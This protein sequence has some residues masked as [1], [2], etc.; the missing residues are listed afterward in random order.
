ML[1]EIT[2]ADAFTRITFPSY[3]PGLRAKV[4]SD[5][6]V[7]KRPDH[8]IEAPM[9]SIRVTV[10][11]IVARM[12][13]RMVLLGI[14]TLR[15]EKVPPNAWLQRRGAARFNSSY[16]A[17]DKMKRMLPPRPLQAIVRLRCGIICIYTL[18]QLLWL[19]RAT[20]SHITS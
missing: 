13:F 20:R 14:R 6:F 16:V 4:H 12:T 7:G 3:A 2:E 17:G 1:E 5:T 18:C 11:E 9:P 15:F 8:N 10:A 19:P